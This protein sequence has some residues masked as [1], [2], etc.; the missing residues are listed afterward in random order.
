[1]KETSSNASVAL[2]T[3]PQKTLANIALGARRIMRNS[4]EVQDRLVGEVVDTSSAVGGGAALG[5]YI[6]RARALKDL[7]AEAIASKRM[8]DPTMDPLTGM[9]PIEVATGFA[10]K[11]VG[12]GLQWFGLRPDRTG[13]DAVRTRRRVVDLVGR[14]CGS[15]SNVALGIAAFNRTAA[16][17]YD[18][19]VAAEMQ[20]RG[21]YQGEPP[22][23]QSQGEQASAA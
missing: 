6:G 7:N 16:A 9:L 19:T 12:L 8:K 17:T 15:F 13:S 3:L 23:E 10:T 20:R 14:G 21:G 2:E 18:R 22:R 4:Q 11:F 1:M 5:A